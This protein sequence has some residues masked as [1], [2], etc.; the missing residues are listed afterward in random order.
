MARYSLGN[1]GL[2]F[3]TA[4]AAI[5]FHF[6]SLLLLLLLFVV[7]FSLLA[8]VVVGRRTTKRRRRRGGGDFL[9]CW[10]SCGFFWRFFRGFEVGL[11]LDFRGRVV[12]NAWN[13]Q[14]YFQDSLGDSQW[15]CRDSPDFLLFRT[16]YRSRGVVFLIRGPDRANSLG[17]LRDSWRLFRIL[18]DSCGFLQQS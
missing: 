3:L 16:S 6:L 8:V 18:R 11:A 5:M 17:I 2:G 1:F 13:F 4:S 10:D 9:F 15:F 14:W 12:G 7:L